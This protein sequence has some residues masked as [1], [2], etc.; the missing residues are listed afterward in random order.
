MEDFDGLVAAITGG[1]GGIGAATAR[2]LADRGARVVV[3]DTTEALDGP[4]RSLWCDV[5]DRSS[6]EAA[7]AE[8]ASSYGG[9]DVLVHAAGVGAV[10]DVAAGD[11]EE[12]RRVLDI[13][14][15]GVARVTAAALPHLRDSG[16]AV[17]VTVGSAVVSVGVPERAAYT[18]SKGAV[19]ALT[20]AMAADYVRDGIRVV[21]VAPGTTDTAWVQRL[22]ASSGDADE[23]MRRLRQRQ[24]IGR[25]VAPEEV[26]RAIAFL[27]SPGS[28]AT[29][30]A[31]LAVDGGMTGLRLP[32]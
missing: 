6:V 20:L 27:A 12:W 11:D 28:G 4:W 32:S 19:H 14:V 2:E 1:A 16:S 10:G 7:V 21:G 29:T 22:L 5:T 23:A 17:V 3:L 8:I 25:L 24:A 9:L 31:I 18:A 15:V 13:N 30:G 26:A